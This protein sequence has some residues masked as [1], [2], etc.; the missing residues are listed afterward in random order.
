MFRYML[1]VK[2]T[3]CCEI[4]NVARIH[5]RKTVHVTQ[6]RWVFLLQIQEIQAGPDEYRCVG[7]SCDGIKEGT[8][9]A[10]VQGL[11]RFDMLYMHVDFL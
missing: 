1:L 7:T 10:N 5:L 11:K 6:H 3:L 2:V 4:W 8:D 9:C